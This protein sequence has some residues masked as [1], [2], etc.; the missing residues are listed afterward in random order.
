MDC[1]YVL[2]T[3]QWT[4]STQQMIPGI[5]KSANSTMQN[6][7]KLCCSEVLIMNCGSLLLYA[8]TLVQK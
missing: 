1:N 2:N 5:Q 4:K 3:G 6:H 8:E 7:I